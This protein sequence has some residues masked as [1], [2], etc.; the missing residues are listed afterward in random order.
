MDSP[1][2]VI[3]AVAGSI[4]GVLLAGSVMAATTG[5]QI[6]ID[7]EIRLGEAR[8]HPDKVLEAFQE[9]PADGRERTILFMVLTTLGQEKLISADA[10]RGVVERGLVDPEDYIRGHAVHY[11]D[12]VYEGDELH[13]RLNRCTLDRSLLSRYNAAE[14][15]AQF[16]SVESVPYL[17]ALLGDESI[18]VRDRA[19]GTLWTWHRGGSVPDIKDV[20]L[21]AAESKNIRRAGCAAR[22]LPAL[23]VAPRLDLLHQY[24]DGELNQPR[25]NFHS[26]NVNCIIRVLGDIGDP[27]SKSVLEQAAKH[28]HDSVAAAANDALKSRAGRRSTTLK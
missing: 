20:F 8:K 9:T 27:S 19:V 15:L 16:P 1:R 7:V 6:V 21:R 22:V 14:K 13:Q 4:A 17:D 26:D 23:G 18:E 10:L 11:L 2:G 12:R 28:W 25:S 5:S 24:L 3:I